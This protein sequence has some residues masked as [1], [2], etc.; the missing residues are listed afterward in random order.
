MS[1]EITPPESVISP[2][3]HWS[4]TKVLEADREGVS[5]AVGKW[6]YNPVLAIRWNG[7]KDNPIG[8]PQSRGLPT[9]FILPQWTFK[10][11][12]E[13]LPLEKQAFAKLFLERI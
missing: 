7:T 1:R 3:T 6:D 13:Q 4:L 10:A 9:W 2:K 8:N 11:I 12:L 5:L